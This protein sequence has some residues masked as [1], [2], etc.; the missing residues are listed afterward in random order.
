MPVC[1]CSVCNCMLCDCVHCDC[2]VC[3]ARVCTLCGSCGLCECFPCCRVSVLCACPEPGAPSP[4]AR[5]TA[6]R[7]GE[8][9]L[10]PR[11]AGAQLPAE[12]S[13]TEDVACAVLPFLSSAFFPGRQRCGEPVRGAGGRALRS[14][15]QLRSQAQ[16]PRGRHLFQLHAS[17]SV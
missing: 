4:R 3:C 14:W 16:T 1:V 10:P 17:Q 5:C 9:Q 6:V 7:W 2:S 15:T 11:E 13:A 12:P 8:A